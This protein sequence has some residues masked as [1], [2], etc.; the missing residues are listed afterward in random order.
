LHVYAADLGRTQDG[1]WWVLADRT[2]SPAGAG[3]ALENRIILSSVLSD[4]FLTSQVHRLAAFFAALQR[5]LIAMAPR[6][7][8]DPRIVLL[9]PGP[10]NETYFEHAYLA[11]YLGYTLVE[12]A[13]L[14]VRDQVV[15]LKTLAG[16]Q[17]V[18]VILRRLDDAFCDPLVL[19]PDSILGVAGLVQAVRAGNVAIANA[20]GSGWLESAALLPLLPALCR[21]LLGEELRLPSVPTWWCGEAQALAYVLDHLEDLMLTPALPTGV[22]EAMLAAGTSAS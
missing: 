9:T 12:G 20:L 14:T 13:D 6:H 2:Q 19:Q 8:D 5:L 21:R 18:D 1:Q 22:R 10:Y 7:R 11:R 3:Y 4:L 16:L 17:P 15:F